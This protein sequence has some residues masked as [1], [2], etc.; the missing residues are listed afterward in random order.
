MSALD[1]RNIKEFIVRVENREHT[2]R[3]IS[4]GRQGEIF[5]ELTDQSAGESGMGK[6]GTVFFLWE[7]VWHYFTC[8]IFCPTLRRM[9]IVRTS[10]IAVDSRKERRYECGL[11]GGRITEKGI[12]HGS[13]DITILNISRTGIRFETRQPL[14]VGRTYSI[15]MRLVIK[16]FSETVRAECV[17]LNELHAGSTYHYGCEIVAITPE[18][19]ALLEKYL[20]ILAK[21]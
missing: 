19:L 18:N 4:T 6:N 13:I 3:L 1:L 7:G 14:K 15:E 11:L 17:I 21:A 5:V 9:T 10:P 20:A 16:H 12:L 2:A 8:K